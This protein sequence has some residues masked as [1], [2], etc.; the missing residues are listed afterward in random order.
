MLHYLRRQERLTQRELAI[1]VGYSESMIS[2]LE[3]G[4][5]VPDTATILALFVPA[6][7][8]AGQSDVVAQFVRLAEQSR[9]EVAG[10]DKEYSPKEGGHSRRTALMQLRLP[11]RLTSFV[12]REDDVLALAKQL[13][14]SRL[15]TLTGPGGSGKTSLAVE[16]CRWLINSEAQVLQASGI[17]WTADPD[18]VAFIELYPLSDQSLLVQAVL[19]ALGVEGSQEQDSL[20]VLLNTIDERYVL[21]VLDNCEHFVDDVARFAQTLLRR[22]PNLRILA[23]SRERLNIAPESVY[24]VAP[25][26]C[27]QER[28]LPNF[29]DIASSPAVRLFV[30][31]SQAVT[32]AMQLTPQ[33]AIAIAQICTLLD[34]VPLAL[35]LGAAATAT[36]SV[37]E[38]AGRLSLGV[39][40]T[41]PG[42]RDAE[43]RHGSINDTIAWSYNLLAPAEQRLLA[44]LAVFA[45]GWTLEALAQVCTDMRSCTAVL[46]RL[47]QKSLVHVENGEAG[48]S[49]TRY[50]LLRA[51]REYAA[52]R[53]A[54]YGD[55]ASVRRRHFAFYMHLGVTLGD[56]VLGA[57]HAAAMAG[58]DAD[59]PNLCAALA[60]AAGNAD[61]AERYAQLAA[62]LPFYWRRRGY[63]SEGLGWL[64]PIMNDEGLLSLPT[65]AL[66]Y[67]AVLLLRFDAPTKGYQHLDVDKDGVGMLARADALIK[68]C[69]EQG[70]EG[71]AARLMITVASL[72][73]YPG[74]ELRAATYASRAWEI[75]EHSGDMR[76]AALACNLLTRILIDQGNVEAAQRV[77]GGAV[78]S[79]AQHSM[80]WALCEAYRLD[81]HI[82]ELKNDRATMIRDLI[83]LAEIAEQEQFVPFLHNVFGELEREEPET[84]LRMA[85][86]LLARQHKLGP[87]V[88]LALAL[89]QL[90]RMCINTGRYQDAARFLDEALEL[91]ARLGEVQGVGIGTRWSLLDRGQAARFMGDKALAIACF[92]E[93]LR[94]L[95]TDP[96]HIYPLLAR[97]QARF[98]FADLDGA[99]EDYRACLR[100]AVG[101]PDG[102]R[103]F[104]VYCL[105]GIG[106]VA[107]LRGDIV[108]AAKLWAACATFYDKWKTVETFG[109][110][111]QAIQFQRVMAA[112]LQR[113]D[114]PVFAAAWKQGNVLKFDEMISLALAIQ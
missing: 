78:H 94:L 9:R 69:L 103:H 91:W 11:V 76:G 34:G 8:V 18:A 15:V 27:P 92:G 102:W 37:Q 60:F 80:T 55:E 25:L 56:R 23:T 96:F 29:A 77:H 21:L 89:H 44:E 52:E 104:I 107:Y 41:S 74:S 61:L 4:D 101:D 6:L 73:H 26:A 14:R 46:H 90:G 43:P 31:R 114:D 84:A 98:E 22:C 3:H 33:N 53:L 2:R 86:A 10:K 93:S 59:Y 66:V 81:A 30:E 48:A 70:E 57:Q 36:F 82:A 40:L 68:P 12:G 112:A 67:A 13:V 20:Q 47:V 38:I 62:A 83:L 64:R 72:E 111:H 17:A 24:A 1:A 63:V 75:F 105:A 88:V 32:A 45:G 97:G 39:L 87:S 58:L 95:A 54:V 42:Y 99:L 65:R 5:R 79:F 49:A 35:E 50:Y 110:P 16:T 28:P 106:E 113:R 7:H 109:Q 108:G 51:V 85:E 100:Q 71:A 19:A